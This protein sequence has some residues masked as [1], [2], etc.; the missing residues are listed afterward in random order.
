MYML[1]FL[2]TAFLMADIISLGAFLL[3][4]L[5][6]DKLIVVSVLCLLAGY[7]FQDKFYNKLYNFFT[8]KRRNN[9]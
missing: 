2:I 5:I 4:T 8:K 9:E 3:P 1:C 7:F 6:F